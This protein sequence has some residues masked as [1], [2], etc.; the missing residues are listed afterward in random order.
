MSRPAIP[1][2][3]EAP[4]AGVG[5]RFMA[6]LL[7]GV[8]VSGKAGEHFAAEFTALIPGVLI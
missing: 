7:I 3:I 1:G 2:F 8:E 5:G 6:R 4:L